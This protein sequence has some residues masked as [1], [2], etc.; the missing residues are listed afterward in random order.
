MNG[1]QCVNRVSMVGGVMGELGRTQG[2]REYEADYGRKPASIEI[3][4]VGR[5]YNELDRRELI[6]YLAPPPFVRLY[7]I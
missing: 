6:H 4:S 7:P 2:R 3:I 1:E 5:L